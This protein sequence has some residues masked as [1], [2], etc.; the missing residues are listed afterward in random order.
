MRRDA[1]RRKHVLLLRSRTL[2]ARLI[3]DTL[4]IAP[5][6]GTIQSSLRILARV[7]QHPEWLATAA[8]GLLLL[9]PARLTA[10]TRGVSFGLRTWRQLLPL[11]AALR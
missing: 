6:V 9:R 11:L 10:W 3:H 4:G 7:R 2:R 1:A 5:T 8:L